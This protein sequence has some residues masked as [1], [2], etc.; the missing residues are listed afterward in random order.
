[1][2][3]RLV[4]VLLVLVLSRASAVAADPLS[5][6]VSVVPLQTFVE[7]I[8]GDHTQVVTLVQPG[9]NPHA[10]E[11][12]ARQIASLA[13]ADLYVRTGVGFEQAWMSRLQAANP[14][15]TLLDA[16]DGL[17][18]RE[19]D[20]HH[21]HGHD[22]DHG[23]ADP[24]DAIDPHVWTSPQ[25]VKLMAARIRDALT[26]LAS[27]HAAAFQANY[28]RFAADLEALDEEIRA[29]LASL[30]D[31][32]FMVYHPAWGY[33][34][35]DYGLTQIAIEHEGKEPGPRALARLIEQARQR[36]TRVIFV[37]PQ[38]NSAAA[39]QIAAAIGGE[40]VVIDPLSGDYFNN[41]RH[42]AK[43]LAPEQD[44]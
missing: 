26:A 42:L 24:L 9:Q 6:F 12:T 11:P 25:R 34:A 7:R 23:H 19:H 13:A 17:E 43:Q 14:R 1:M 16:R 38:Y 41:L 10:Y 21:H 40:V 44:S 32:H 22:H 35:D 31:R 28:D 20:H 15:M 30:D 5:V 37:E 29:R 36:G 33:F 3:E 39:E 27:E 8:G 2:R 18:G 4:S